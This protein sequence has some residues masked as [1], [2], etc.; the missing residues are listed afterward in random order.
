MNRLSLWSLAFSCALI[1]L[2]AGC[3]SITPSVSYYILNSVT[4]GPMSPAE[5]DGNL[6]KAIGIKPIRLP[7]Y[8]NR[9]QMVKRTGPNQLEISSRHR[10]A[11]YPDRMIQRVFG[12]NLQMLMADARVYSAPWPA[13]LKPDITVDVTFLDLIGK[14]DQKMLLNAVWT[15]TVDGAPLPSHRTTLSETI[16]GTGFDDLAAAHSRVLESLCREVADTLTGL[17]VH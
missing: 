3:R 13:G 17:P 11:D 16:T 9:A 12:D 15:I 4:E 14:T 10:W 1:I 2:F 5:A 6:T 7:G 8:L